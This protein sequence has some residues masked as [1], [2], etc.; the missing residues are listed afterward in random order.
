MYV[1]HDGG[2]NWSLFNKELVPG[3]PLGIGGEDPN[4]VVGV[5]KDGLVE[6]HDRGHSWTAIGEQAFFNQ[7]TGIMGEHTKGERTKLDEM[8][9][10]VRQPNEP[11][12]TRIRVDQIELSSASKD[13]IY[14]R[15]NIG[16]IISR[17]GGRT[18]CVAGQGNQAFDEINGLTVSRNRPNEVLIS[19]TATAKLPSRILRSTDGGCTFTVLYTMGLRS[20]DDRARA[21]SMAKTRPK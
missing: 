7:A 14:L 5:R 6:S 10:R 12:G 16:L 21:R 1:S 13:T 2:D 9:R 15:T 20:S 3:A 4:F 8:A 17:D 18:W 19:T 11:I